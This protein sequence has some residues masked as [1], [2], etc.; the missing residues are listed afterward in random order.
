MEEL[1]NNQQKVIFSW[2]GASHQN[3]SAVQTIN[4]VVDIE[5]TMLIHAAIICPKDTFFTYFRQCKWTIL[6]GYI[7]GSLICSMVY[8]LLGKFETYIFWRQC[9]R[10]P[11]WKPLNWIQGVK[12]GLL[13][14]YAR[15]TQ[16]N[17]GWFWIWWMVW[18]HWSF[19]LYW[20]YIV[21]C[22]EKHRPR[23]R[24]LDKAS[25][26]K[27][28]KDQVHVR[29]IKCSELDYGWLTDNEQLTRFRKA[30]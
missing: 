3:G 14:D 19:I 7:V 5:S 30:R 29:P 13:W 25:H 12:E 9:S 18:D 21:L 26:I 6:F 2:D 22:C 16:H 28:I 20:L 17:L 24:S 1:L 11:D 4:M 15:F 10:S 27:E 23:Y 8:K